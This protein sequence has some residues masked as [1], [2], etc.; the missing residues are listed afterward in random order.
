MPE[1]TGPQEHEQEQLLSLATANDAVPPAVA[2]NEDG[3]TEIAA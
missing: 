1:P 2:L 3:A